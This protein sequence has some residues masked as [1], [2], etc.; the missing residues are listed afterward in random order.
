MSRTT[1]FVLD[2]NVF[3]QANRQYYPFDVCP[4]FW[5]AL[6]AHH[7]GRRVYSDTVPD[8]FFEQTADKSVI[9][10]YAEMVA[11]VQRRAQYNDE[12]KAEFA[13]VADGWLIAYA[14]CNGLTVV[15][16]E[17]HNPEIKKRVPIPNVCEKY[18][19]PYI[20]TIELL[21]D[22]GVRLVMSVKKAGTK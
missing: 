10:K 22:L 9:D 11:W 8:A 2:A 12:A 7:H 6:V 17:V 1:K 18:D 20:N 15:T 13:S 5:K 19:V 4:G 16:Q 21:R 3:I 14:A